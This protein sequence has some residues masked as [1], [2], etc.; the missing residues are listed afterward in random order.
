MSF[1]K[2]AAYQFVGAIFKLLILTLPVLFAIAIVLGNPNTIQ[3]ALKESR[4]YDQIVDVALD[5]SRDTVND[6]NTKTLLSDPEIRAAVQKSIT[7]QVLEQSTGSVVGGI[8][9]WL[10]GKTAEPIFSIDLSDAKNS[11]SKNLATYAEKR[12]AALPVC[13]VAQLRTINLQEDLLS[14]PCQPPGTNASAVGQQFS[15]QLLSDIDLLDKPIITSQ[16]IKDENNGRSIVAD[17][18]ALPD[19]Y[20]GVQTGKWIVLGVTIALGLL[21]IFGRRNRKAG[22]QHVAWALIGTATF[23]II[24]LLIYWFVFDRA[25]QGRANA[26]AIQAMWLDG[27]KAVLRNFNEVVSWFVG[28]YLAIGGG[29][30]LALRIHTKRNKPVT[31]SSEPTTTNPEKPIIES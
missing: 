10:Q 3:G 17:A 22:L 28:A 27:G 5:N 18:N 11:L 21:L 15:E 16:T 2:K 19:L 8:Y 4:V 14:L 7:P 25:N 9:G 23:F 13:T 12:V 26:D 30:L 6:A 20:S 1:I 24:A 29:M 31:D